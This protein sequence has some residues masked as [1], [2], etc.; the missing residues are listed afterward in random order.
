M[1]NSKTYYYVPSIF[2]NIANSNLNYYSRLYVFFMSFTWQPFS[3]WF[4]YMCKNLNEF[5]K[6]KINILSFLGSVSMFH[7]FTFILLQI[8]HFCPMLNNAYFMLAHFVSTNKQNSIK[9]KLHLFSLIL[10]PFFLDIYLAIELT[11][12]WH[13]LTMH[14]KILIEIITPLNGSY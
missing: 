14:E 5:F 8:T 7:L 1:R 3:V 4:I 13:L 12:L 2:G 6:M 9:F 11:T 10:F